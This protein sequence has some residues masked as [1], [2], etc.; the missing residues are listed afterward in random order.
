MLSLFWSY[1]LV[2]AFVYRLLTNVVH[3]LNEHELPGFMKKVYVCKRHDIFEN[4]ASQ[5]SQ[6]GLVGGDVWCVL[7]QRWW[8]AWK[9]FVNFDGAPEPL[10]VPFFPPQISLFSLFVLS[11]CFVLSYVCLRCFY[12]HLP[13]FHCIQTDL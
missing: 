2:F 1:S 3:I 6:R 12:V 10:E 13:W 11:Y 7:N 4:L 5:V 9:E 8:V